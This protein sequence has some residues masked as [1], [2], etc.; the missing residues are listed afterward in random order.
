MNK[1]VQTAVRYLI[2][3]LLVCGTQVFQCVGRHKKKKK[4]VRNT[5]DMG[6]KERPRHNHQLA[7]KMSE[8]N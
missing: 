2:V 3:S 5:H 8:Y 6:A 7:A 1:G 4:T